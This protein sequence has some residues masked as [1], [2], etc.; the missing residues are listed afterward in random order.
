MARYEAYQLPHQL[1]AEGHRLRALVKRAAL[2]HIPF[3]QQVHHVVVPAHVSLDD[4]ARAGVDDARPVGVLRLRRQ[5]AQHREAGV[6]ERHR[7]V[8][9]GPL[10]GH[11]GMLKA[12]SLESRV[13]VVDACLQVFHPF[14]GRGRV[15]VVYDLLL[16]LHQAPGLIGR[17]VLRLQAVAH[18]DSLVLGGL[19]LIAELCYLVVE[20]A[21][22]LV[23]VAGLHGRLR[24]Q[25]DARVERQRGSPRLRCR[26]AA[27]VHAVGAQRLYLYINRIGLD[28]VNKR[29]V[30]GQ[31]ADA[32][33]RA[34]AA[35]EACYLVVA[36]YPLR[37]VDQPCLGIRVAANDFKLIDD[38]VYRR[39][40]QRDG[41]AVVGLGKA[42][43]HVF[44]EKQRLVVILL[45]VDGRAVHLL[46]A[47]HLEI[48]RHAGEAR[49]AQQHAPQQL[50][51]HLPVPVVLDMAHG[52]QAVTLRAA[53]FHHLVV[54]VFM[55]LY[56]GVVA[57]VVNLVTLFLL[58]SLHAVGLRLCA[59]LR[60]HHGVG[61]HGVTGHYQP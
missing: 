2:H 6:V 46:A 53:V 23:V 39:L 22:A 5:V 59:V 57:A 37:H 45:Q 19:L 54:R 7:R 30:A 40:F 43:L 24:Q 27:G 20:V 12:R 28:T 41:Y 13:P 50:V 9:L 3:F 33:L 35:R 21:Y 26:R 4:F 60:H 61:L 34:V 49:H 8:V 42:R 36:L 32:Q 29:A 44:P 58:D 25:H 15:N 31:T 14:L 17:S 11:D 38:R 16:G 52:H 47:E 55:V 10:L 1:V 51:G 48:L 56:S 18:D